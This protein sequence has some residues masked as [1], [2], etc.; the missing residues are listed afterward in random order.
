MQNFLRRLGFFLVGLIFGIIILKFF[1]SK[2]NV[3]FDYFPN[4]R[5][6]KSL[7]NKPHLQISDKAIF[8]MNENGI[9]T[10]SI[11]EFFMHGKVNFDKSQVHSEPCKSYYIEQTP[12]TKPFNI[13]V[14]R[15]DSVVLVKEILKN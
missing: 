1:F 5:T 14:E 11:R 8:E 6:L 9:D 12:K 7:R 13:I 3:E 2:K 10:A 15:C 4:D